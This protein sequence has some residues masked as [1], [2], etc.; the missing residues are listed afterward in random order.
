MVHIQFDIDGDIELSRNLGVFVTQL[1][2]M[3]PFYE[4]ATDLIAKK[5][6]SLFRQK[7]Q[8][9]EKGAKWKPLAPS[10]K[11]AREKRW[12]YYKQPPN[13]PSLMRW[14][15][16]LE[17]SIYRKI[18]QKQGEVGYNAD[19]AIHHQKPEKDG[20]P[21]TRK[22]IDLDNAT[23]AEIVRSMQKTINNKIGISGLQF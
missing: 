6:H 23:N 5:S 2:D 3:T 13:S 21:P 8:N 16:N 9:V 10:T 19:Y 1:K 4:D 20:K 12:G 22:L 11:K 17:G 15:G 7:G 18:S 14:T